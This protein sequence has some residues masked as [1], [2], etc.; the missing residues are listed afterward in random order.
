[1]TLNDI[2]LR[3]WECKDCHGQSA[4]PLMFESEEAYAEAKTA[5]NSEVSRES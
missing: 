2:A 4:A 3:L 1:M 5:W